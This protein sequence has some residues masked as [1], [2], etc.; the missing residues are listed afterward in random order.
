MFPG[1]D[2]RD[3]QIAKGSIVPSSRWHIPAMSALLY[4][5][6]GFSL[7]RTYVFTCLYLFLKRILYYPWNR[8]FNVPAEFFPNAHFK[9][10]DYSD[11]Y[12]SLRYPL[13]SSL[14]HQ[15]VNALL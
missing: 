3:S 12:Q 11:K 15:K 6:D 8:K 7:S 2:S 14:S 4:F 9:M 10:Y 1:M 5:L 13:T